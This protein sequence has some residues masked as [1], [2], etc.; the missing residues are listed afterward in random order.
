M[1]TTY[2]VQLVYAMFALCTFSSSILTGQVAP[3]VF[4][5]LKEQRHSAYRLEK[6]AGRILDVVKLPRIEDARC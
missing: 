1:Q 3:E 2:S 6:L 4:Q 5:A